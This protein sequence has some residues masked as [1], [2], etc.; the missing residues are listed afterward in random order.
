MYEKFDIMPDIDN[1]YEEIETW[2]GD[3]DGSVGG[4]YGM[5]FYFYYF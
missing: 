4:R 1:C 5:I 2:E 3:R